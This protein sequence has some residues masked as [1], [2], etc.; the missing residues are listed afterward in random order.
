MRNK[1]ILVIIAA[2]LSGETL[3]ADPLS[4]ARFTE[5]TWIPASPHQLRVLGLSKLKR[6]EHAHFTPVSESWVDTYKA[7]PVSPH[8]LKVIRLSRK[9]AFLHP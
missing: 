9:L 7:V 2:L 6:A 8:Q 5:P 1:I 3:A 4:S